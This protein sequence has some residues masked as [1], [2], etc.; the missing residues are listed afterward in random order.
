MRRSFSLVCKK[1]VWR[2]YGGV[3]GNGVEGKKLYS[4]GR[5]GRVFSV[6]RGGGGAVMG[7]G[8]KGL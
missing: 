5:G 7:L 6:K 2:G 3:T 1:G 4:A 8:R